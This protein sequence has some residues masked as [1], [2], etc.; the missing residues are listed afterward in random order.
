MK[1]GVTDENRSNALTTIKKH[2]EAT[3]SLRQQFA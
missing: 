2:E 1:D 3:E